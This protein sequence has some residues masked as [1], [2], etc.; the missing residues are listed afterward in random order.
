[1]DSKIGDIVYNAINEAVDG[2]IKVYPLIQT[3][4]NGCLPFIVYR[5]SGFAPSYTKDLYCKV[6]DYFYSI[7]IVSDIYKVGVDL[8]DKVIDS[9]TSLTGQTINGKNIGSVQ[10]T[11]ASEICGEDVLFVQNVDFQIKITK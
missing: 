4:E 10:V 1:M 3:D 11:N 7:A 5:R 9:L 6:D 8:V 2:K